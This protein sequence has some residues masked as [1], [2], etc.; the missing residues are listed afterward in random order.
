M[1]PFLQLAL[2]SRNKDYPECPWVFHYQGR[3]I[4]GH[5]KGWSDACTTAGVPGLHFHDLRRSAVR[6]ME[7]AGIPRHVAMGISGHRTEAVYRRYDIVSGR[8]LQDAGRKLES[9]LT[10]KWNPKTE[11]AGTQPGEVSHTIR[12]QKARGVH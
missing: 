6:A 5:V 4:G 9:C 7:R 8:D 3:R 1:R 12:T 11:A 10:A 2:E